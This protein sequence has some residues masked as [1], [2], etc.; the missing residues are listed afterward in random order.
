[1]STFEPGETLTVAIPLVAADDFY[2]HIAATEQLEDGAAPIT[3]RELHA[4]MLAADPRYTAQ[5]DEHGHFITATP[6][7]P[8]LS[9]GSPDAV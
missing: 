7:T 5:F 1:M 3:L 2:A 6:N 9:N 8:T 4:R